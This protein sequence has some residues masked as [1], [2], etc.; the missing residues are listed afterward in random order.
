[1][2]RD[3]RYRYRLAPYNKYQLPPC[4]EQSKATLST[5]ENSLWPE[6]NSLTLHNDKIM[7][8][9]LDGECRLSDCAGEGFVSITDPRFARKETVWTLTPKNLSRNIQVQ[10]FSATKGEREVYKVK[11]EGGS[12]TTR[13]V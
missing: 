10:L 3:R 13:I 9:V 1:M 5:S 6:C 2:Q 4:E 8:L 7:D 12:L 11:W